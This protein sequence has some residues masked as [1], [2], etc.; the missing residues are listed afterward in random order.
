MEDLY[1]RYADR[2]TRPSKEE[3]YTI[4]VTVISSCSKVFII[5]YAEDE[6]GDGRSELLDLLYSLRDQTDTSL[7]V[8]SRSA[9]VSEQ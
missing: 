5:I 2:G 9:M 1:N 7:M 6:C 4:L 8:I 3:I